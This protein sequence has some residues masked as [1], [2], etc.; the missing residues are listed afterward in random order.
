MPIIRIPKN[1]KNPFFMMDNNTI[2]NSKLSLQATA[3][4]TY[5]I[6]KPDNWHV[7]ILDIVSHFTNGECSVRSAM[8]ELVAAGYIV[9][10]RVYRKNGKMLRY[11]YI[12]HENPFIS[13]PNINKLH[14]DSPKP[15]HDFKQV[16][17]RKHTN[18]DIKDNTD[19]KN[20]AYTTKEV[21]TNSSVD[22][23]I[24]NKYKDSLIKLFKKLNIIDHETLFRLFSF[25]DLQKYTSWISKCN[26]TIKNP[27]GYLIAAIKGKWH[28]EATETI[29]HND[30]RYHWYISGDL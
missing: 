1:S 16:V 6:S 30:D 2:N 10:K 5:L 7:R 27:T 12:V 25:K 9:H 8:K 21:N 3:V 17:N 19:K 20:V 13:N 29:E 22:V 18:T 24:S 4:L 28:D 14:K 15:L 26:T 11:D 23:P